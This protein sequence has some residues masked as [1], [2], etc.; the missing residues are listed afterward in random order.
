[1]PELSTITKALRLRRYELAFGQVL[2]TNFVNLSLL[3]IADAVFTGEAVMNELGRFESVSALLGAMLIG[4]VLIGLLER[5][6]AT[7]FRM[8]Y[9][10]FIVILLF[11]GGLGILA[12]I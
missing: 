12:A 2:G 5:R 8:G 1:M 10:S 7:I 3:L 4:I 6:N 9:D 11:F